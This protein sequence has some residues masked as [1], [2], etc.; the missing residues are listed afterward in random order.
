[1]FYCTP[2]LFRAG[3]RTRTLSTARNPI[4][5]A[6]TAIFQRKP[7]LSTTACNCRMAIFPQ[8]R[9][10]PWE[11]GCIFDLNSFVPAN[12]DLHLFEADFI[13]D[14][15][16]ITGPAFLTNGEVHQY[17]LLRCGARDRVGCS[18]SEKHEGRPVRSSPSTTQRFTKSTTRELIATIFPTFV[19]GCEM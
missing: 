7:S 14:R 6:T 8:E 11:R 10:F 16:D 2:R 13:N 12:S 19:G 15:G 4:P 3:P 18:E 9:A 1:M 17:L 5:R